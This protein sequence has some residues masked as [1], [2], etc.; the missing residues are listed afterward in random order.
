MT[1]SNTM[2]RDANLRIVEATELIR[3]IGPECHHRRSNF[4]YADPGTLEP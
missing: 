2:I 3:N 1:I 4:N